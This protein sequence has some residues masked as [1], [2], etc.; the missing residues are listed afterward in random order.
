MSEKEWWEPVLTD[1]AWVASI[2]E[3]YPEECEGLGDDGVREEYA[4]GWK[5][6]TLWDNLGD[7]REEHEALA[8]AY[9]A[10]RAENAAL[11]DQLAHIGCA[12]MSAMPKK[13]GGGP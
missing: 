3:E 2:R 1:A 9:M 5:Y 6:C 13:I 11:K 12:G 8:D 4:D 7:A 10:L